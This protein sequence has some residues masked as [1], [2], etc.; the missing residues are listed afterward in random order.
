[1]VLLRKY[2]YRL[3]IPSRHYRTLNPLSIALFSGEELFSYPG[4]KERKKV[5]YLPLSERGGGG[6][7]SCLFSSQAPYPYLF[8]GWHNKERE[9]QERTHT[10]HFWRVRDRQ[11]APIDVKTWLPLNRHY[12]L[13]APTTCPSFTKIPGF[14]RFS[15][16]K[17]ARQ[18]KN[19]G[20]PSLRKVSRG[21]TSS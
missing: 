15:E 13:S 12:Y 10:H 9:C 20:A 16:T 19:R 2:G 6:S 21:W 11:G 5:P 17:V 4:L 1:M 18:A 8:L 7:A 3:L 14:M